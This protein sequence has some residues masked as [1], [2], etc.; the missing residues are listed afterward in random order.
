MA[1]GCEIREVFMRKHE[2]QSLQH[3]M[4]PQSASI[5]RNDSTPSIGMKTYLQ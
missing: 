5:R 2:R 4:Y 3:I 1:L